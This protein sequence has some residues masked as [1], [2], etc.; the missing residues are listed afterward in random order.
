MYNFLAKYCRTLQADS[1]ILIFL[2]MPIYITITR[3]QML[4]LMTVVE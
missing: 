4:W 2:T 3:S 1:K